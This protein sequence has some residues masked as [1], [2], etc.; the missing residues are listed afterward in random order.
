MTDSAT[1]MTSSRGDR[2]GVDRGPPQDARGPARSFGRDR[3]G[4][5]LDEPCPVLD[6]PGDE[7]SRLTGA[8]LVTQKVKLLSLMAGSFQPIVEGNRH[9]LEYNVIKDIRSARTLAER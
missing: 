3:P 4:W 6:S 1:P 8:E 7:H 9:F 2:P 5:I